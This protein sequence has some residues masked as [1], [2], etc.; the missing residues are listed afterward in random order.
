MSSHTSF[1]ADRHLGHVPCSRDAVDR[2]ALADDVHL[3][4]V[5]IFKSLNPVLMAPAHSASD[6]SGVLGVRPR[7]GRKGSL[8]AQQCMVDSIA[9]RMPARV[10]RVTS[11]M[12]TTKSSRPHFLASRRPTPRASN[13]VWARSRLLPHL[14]EQLKL[15]VARHAS[16]A[17]ETSGQ[18][19]S[20]D[21]SQ[22]SGLRM[23][24]RKANGLLAIEFSLN[25]AFACGHADADMQD[26]HRNPLQPETIGKPGQMKRRAP[27]QQFVE[28]RYF[29][30]MQVRT[31]RMSDSSRLMDHS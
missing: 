29:D 5:K 19:A 28:A 18:R 24:V 2:L 20:Q 27:W 23:A 25:L 10:E 8:Q 9:S 30:H 3:G 26:A 22:A 4:Q 1:L 12:W 15:V 7:H 17:D 6:S 11:F 14:D 31:S 13:G 16:S 21:I